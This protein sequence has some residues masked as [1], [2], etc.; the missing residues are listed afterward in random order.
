MDFDDANEKV[1]RNLV[2]ASAVILLLAWLHIP[3]G[4]V[5]DRFFSGAVRVPDWR[6]WATEFTLMSYLSLRYNFSQ[7]GG[8]AYRSTFTHPLSRWLIPKIG[9]LVGFLAG[10]A[11]KSKRQSDIFQDSLL[12]KTEI[13]LRNQNAADVF[14][15]RDHMKF[16][17]SIIEQTGNIWKSSYLLDF[18]YKF[19]G[20]EM[21]ARLD[22]VYSISI[23]H[24]VHRM[25]LGLW[26]RAHAF[27][28]SEAAL[29]H[30]APIYLGLLAEAVLWWKV[31]EGYHMIYAI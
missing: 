17:A 1:R 4:L 24:T 13:T 12:E 7:S 29:E 9:W 16:K 2:L 31:G 21:F 5:L 22:G 26:A 6:L 8:E 15:N 23:Q 18:T 14:E 19:A 20:R 10:R 11:M 27:F 25:F 28:Y 3:L 30:A